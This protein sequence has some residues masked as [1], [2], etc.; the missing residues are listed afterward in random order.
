VRFFLPRGWGK[1]NTCKVK[2]EF[3]PRQKDAGVSSSLSLG[4][5]V[6]PKLCS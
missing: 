4:E 2:H 3:N 1:S 5:G 6:S